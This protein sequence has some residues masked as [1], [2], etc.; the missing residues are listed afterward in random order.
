[1]ISAIEAKALATALTL[2]DVEDVIRAKAQQGATDAMFP[3]VRWH[4]DFDP[5]L[6]AAGYTIRLGG[7][8][9]EVVIVEW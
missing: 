4:G 5:V 1:M 8:N 6:F 7:M 3:I 2:E 9:D